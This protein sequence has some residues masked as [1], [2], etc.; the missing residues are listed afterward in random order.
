MGS[1]ASG[2]VSIPYWTVVPTMCFLSQLDISLSGQMSKSEKSHI[3]YQMIYL[4]YYISKCVSV[5]E[6][7]SHEMKHLKVD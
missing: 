1:G 5:C 6:M 4:N 3:S 7:I 2:G